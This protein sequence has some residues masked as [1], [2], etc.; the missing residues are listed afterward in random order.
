VNSSLHW[1]AWRCALAMPSKLALKHHSLSN[2]QVLLLRLCDERGEHWTEAAPLPGW[3]TDSLN[4]NE[5]ALAQLKDKTPQQALKLNL[6]QA[7]STAMGL[8]TFPN[9]NK[10]SKPVES[11]YLLLN[12]ADLTEAALHSR[13]VKIKVGQL[14]IEQD[15]QRISVLLKQ[16]P[17]TVKIR[18]DSNQSWGYNEIEQLNKNF[19]HESR[20]DYIEEPLLP[21][22]NYQQWSQYSELAFAHDERLACKT[23][24][25][26]PLCKALVVKP[27]ILG[28]QRTLDCHQW[29]LQHNK[30]VILS[31]SFESALGLNLL[32][33]L[34]LHWLQT[35]PQ[36][37]ATEA[38]FDNPFDHYFSAQSSI[39]NT[40][41]PLANLRNV[42]RIL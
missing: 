29:A 13:T 7:L 34:A 15:I 30:E 19:S 39:E 22:L 1:S 27:T 24:I 41:L 20:I 6:P 38:F 33:N 17:T 32:N 31:S 11:N 12:H 21:E 14:D 26:D 23:F 2:R 10:Q 36:G 37:L 35:N 42:D 25:P 16:L 5:T 40:K 9:T 18:L 28:W 3:S 4:D 8:L